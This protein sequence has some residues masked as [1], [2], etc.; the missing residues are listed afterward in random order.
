MSVRA[1]GEQMLALMLFVKRGTTEAAALLRQLKV[2]FKSFAEMQ[3][4]SKL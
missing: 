3:G 1:G 4:R 2:L